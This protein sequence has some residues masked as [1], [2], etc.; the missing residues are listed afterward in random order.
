MIDAKTIET[1]RNYGTISMYEEGGGSLIGRG[2]ILA[3]WLVSN[4]NAIADDLE[5]LERLKEELNSAE[6][7]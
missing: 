7:Y 5:E 3:T 1:L 4:A 6:S 2:F